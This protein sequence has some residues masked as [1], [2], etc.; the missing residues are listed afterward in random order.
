MP[1]SLVPGDVKRGITL[2]NLLYTFYYF[3]SD[4]FTN[5]VLI[6]DAIAFGLQNGMLTESMFMFR[7][8]YEMARIIGRISPTL[9]FFLTERELYTQAYVLSEDE[10]L[11]LADDLDALKDV[12]VTTINPYPNP[13]MTKAGSLVVDDPGAVRPYLDVVSQR[14]GVTTGGEHSYSLALRQQNVA[15]AVEGKWYMVI[16]VSERSKKRMMDLLSE[17]KPLDPGRHA[18][19]YW[20]RPINI[21]GKKISVSLRDELLPDSISIGSSE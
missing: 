17:Y 1:V 20:T 10:L 3:G 7:N 13:I 9:E 21:G 11:R 2:Q 8:D 6:Q 15:E 5:E 14:R 4:R 19:K 16:Q 18:I 12:L